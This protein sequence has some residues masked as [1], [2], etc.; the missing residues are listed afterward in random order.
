MFGRKKNKGRKWRRT[1]GACVCLRR[2]EGSRLNPLF[3][4]TSPLVVF[5]NFKVEAALAGPA[6]AAPRAALGDGHPERRGGWRP[7]QPRQAEMANEEIGAAKQTT[8]F[9]GS[10]DWGLTSEGVAGASAAPPDPPGAGRVRPGGDGGT[11]AAA[12]HA[13]PEAGRRNKVCP[14]ASAQHGRLRFFLRPMTG[15]GSGWRA[16]VGGARDG[17][18]LARPVR[19]ATKGGL[20]AG[21]VGLGVFPAIILGDE[22]PK[23]RPLLGG[24]PPAH[25]PREDGAGSRGH[26]QTPCGDPNPNRP[27]RWAAFFFLGTGLGTSSDSFIVPQI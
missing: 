16:V 13:P 10:F 18:A 4:Q 3:F 5:P 25:S 7:R 9:R 27:C 17:A 1:D 2:R 19:I 6:P 26:L 12:P 21:T 14:G 24:F 11:R 8:A 20:F 22:S 15:P 23:D